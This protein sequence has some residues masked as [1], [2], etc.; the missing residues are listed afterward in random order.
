MKRI[1]ANDGIDKAGKSMLEEAGFF[2]ETNKATEGHLAE[3]I[4][5][6]NFDV[7]LVRSATKVTASLMQYACLLLP[8]GC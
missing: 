5:Q 2:V 7:L 1:L 8:V 4:N 3:T 6:G